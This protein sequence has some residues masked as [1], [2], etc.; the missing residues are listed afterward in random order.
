ML[1]I[2]A[3]SRPAD[4][5]ELHALA[6]SLGMAA[7][8]EVHDRAELEVALSTR[9][10]LLVGSKQPRSARFYRQSGNQPGAASAHIPAGS[11]RGGRKRHPHARL[12]CAAWPQAGVDAILVGEALVTAADIACAGAGVWR[13]TR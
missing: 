13:G 2:V 1:L 7:L 9:T 11:L 10:R 5:A 4:L 6:C 12:T 3:G 8:V